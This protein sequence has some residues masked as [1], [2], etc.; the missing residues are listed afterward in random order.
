MRLLES[1]IRDRHKQ[2]FGQSIQIRSSSLTSMDTFFHQLAA[3]F[4]LIPHRQLS[5]K[6]LAGCYG[7]Y[8]LMRWDIRSMR[9]AEA[10]LWQCCSWS[11]QS[12]AFGCCWKSAGCLSFPGQVGGWVWARHTQRLLSR[13]PSGL[14]RSINCVLLSGTSLVCISVANRVHPC[15]LARLSGRD[16]HANIG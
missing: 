3:L 9:L 2:R 11:P 7:R 4:I 16:M 14:G 5:A 12:V 1:H 6:C 8:S 13:T 15:V 10:L